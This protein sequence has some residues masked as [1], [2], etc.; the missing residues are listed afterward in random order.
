MKRWIINQNL[1]KLR[2]GI[3]ERSFKR[4]LRLV[5]KNLRPPS[6]TG[7]CGCGASGCDP[8]TGCGTSTPV[9]AEGGG[10]GING[11]CDG[12]ITKGHRRR[13]ISSSCRINFAKMQG[14][15]DVLRQAARAITKIKNCNA[16]TD[17]SITIL[18]YVPSC[19]ARLARVCAWARATASAAGA[20]KHA[21]NNLSILIL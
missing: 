21:G 12:T 6:E 15:V 7:V 16:L 20:A 19:C 18:A 3:L 8:I 1:Q 17:C 9:S 5:L 14:I 2:Y 4:S 11:T 10:V 13:R